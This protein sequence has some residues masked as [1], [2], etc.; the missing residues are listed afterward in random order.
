MWQLKKLLWI[1]AM[2]CL[3]VPIAF[4]YELNTIQT[5]ILSN[6][7]NE[8]GGYTGIDMGNPDTARTTDNVQVS[9]TNKIYA[10]AIA[11]L[12]VSRFPFNGLYET[13]ILE[14]YAMPKPLGEPQAGEV[15]IHI[16]SPNPTGDNGTHH[17]QVSTFNTENPCSGMAAG[18]SYPS[19][20][21][22]E[23]CNAT[24]ANST[25][26]QLADVGVGQV[27]FNLTNAT[28]AA[29][30]TNRGNLTYAFVKQAGVGITTF[31]TRHSG[32]RNLGYMQ[33]TFK[34]TFADND[35]PAFSNNSI[36]NTAPRI[37]E[38]VSINISLTDSIGVDG[39]VFQ[40]D[41]G[42]GE[43]VNDS[44]VDIEGLLT[45]NISVNK[46]IKAIAG[47]NITYRWWANDTI[48]NAG[49]SQNYSLI[50]AGTTAP[51]L[52]INGNNFFQ[53]DGKSIIS[54]NQSNKAMINFTITD[55]IDVFGI[56]FNVTN[57]SGDLITNFT[58]TSFYGTIYN[59]SKYINVSSE[60]GFKNVSVEI[61]DSHT[62]SKI[63]NYKVS[64]GLNY[65][66][67]DNQIR[68]TADNAIW[69]NT[70]K[71]W[72]RYDFEFNYLPILTPKVK[73]FYVE[74]NNKLVY[75]EDSK[76][77][78]HFVDFK[79]GKWIDFEG[80]EGE[81]KV[82]K[83][84]DYKYKVQFN[85]TKSKLI[86]SSVGGLNRQ[87]FHYYFYLS[88]PTI[89]F[90][91]P[92]ST[93]NTVVDNFF[94]SFN[95]TGN[96]RNRTVIRLYNSSNDIFDSASVVNNGTGTYFYNHTFTNLPDYIFKV[97]ATHIDVNNENFSTTETFE[98]ENM[99]LTNTS[100]FGG[101]AGVNF[102]IKDETNDSRIR[103][104]MEATGTFTYN[105]TSPTKTY[106]LSEES[107]DNF[108]VFIY[109]ARES[110]ETD[111]YITYKA[112]GYSERSYKTDDAVF[113][114][115]T[116]TISLYL[117]QN[118]DGIVGNIVVVDAEGNA[119]PDV[120][121]T[122]K[123]PSGS[124]VEVRDTDDSGRVSFFVDPD[125]TYTFEFRKSG[126]DTLT[127]SL[128]ITSSDFITINL[129][130]VS[131]EIPPN[132]A[133]GIDY[134]FLP[135]GSTLIN[136]TNYDFVFNMT[137]SYWN[138]TG[139]NLKLKNTSVTLNKS[140]E[141]FNGSQCIIQMTISTGNQSTIISEATYR[142]NNTVNETV[143]V[144]YSVKYV[145]KGE[146]SF[147]VFIDD[148]TSFVSAGFDNFGRFLLAIIIMLI[149]VGTLSMEISAFREPEVLIAVTWVLILFFSYINWMNIP[150]EAIPNVRG[151]PDGWLNQW[152]FFGLATLTG[153]GYL[154][155]KIV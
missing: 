40:W 96:G 79:N 62:A 45:V 128:R 51:E 89:N 3:V 130:G 135:R 88:N 1:I 34:I 103:I 73:I 20:N 27:V 86:F 65:L 30:R 98:F 50:V 92:D 114:N 90:Y 150:F 112:E 138:I 29:I 69:A 115:T 97:N 110:I 36:N 68:I 15:Y 148:L 106:N 93:P 111:Y 85:N 125:T 127:T 120:E 32:G 123:L 37:N 10:T 113:T 133:T 77:K 76:Y 104:G 82:T 31:A 75:R 56:N 54:F 22:A 52:I 44:F 102:T 95:V 13:E 119:I 21:L 25:Y 140:S 33:I 53:E 42:T 122:M 109:P 144:Q 59:F 155:K 134:F 28:Q 70:K 131:E 9:A 66:E 11:Y 101:F 154:I 116:Q 48:G 35:A 8:T 5:I 118:T 6:H 124:I 105:G 136:N 74:S 64:K 142:L 26:V 61:T 41:S 55:D 132:F 63:P 147:K 145:Y 107:K 80:I 91:K 72:D 17:D 60:Q 141:S 39:Y 46:S 100:S 23:A 14:A 57:S 38:N 87:V 143:S 153:G 108:S 121:T 94:V 24:A 7:G 117:L 67:F 4:S 16:V 137:S 19:F 18:D 152:I 149:I 146:Y 78:A 151:L 129:E 49:Y 81:P 2:F 43:L 47:T 12:N 71:K 139:C 58:N 83:I 99:L 84:S 126:Y